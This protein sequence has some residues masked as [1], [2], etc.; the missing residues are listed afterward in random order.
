MT[1]E[2]AAAISRSAIH[3]LG[4]AFTE[5][6]VT[7]R[8]ARQRGLSGWSY[9]VASRGGVLGDVAAGTITAALGMLS[10]ELVGDAW[11]YARR[12]LPPLEVA[13][14]RA[15]ECCRWGSEQLDRF[16]GVGRLV[17]LSGELVASADGTGMPLFAAWRA[18]PSPDVTPGARAAVQLNLLREHRRGAYLIAVRASGLTPVEALVAGPD[19]E[20]AAASCGW[21]GPYPDPGPLIRRRMWLEAVTDRLAGQPFAALR[22][23]ERAE[24]VDLLDEAAAAHFDTPATP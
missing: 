23:A 15:A 12:L 13:A 6:P 19:G 14:Q 7:V 11:E 21:A 18:H 5:C 2:H 9:H 20:A 17:A 1:P 3:Y 8:R 16:P 10:P 4:D 24:L 22:P